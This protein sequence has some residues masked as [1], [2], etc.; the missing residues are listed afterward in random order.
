LFH[1][2]NALEEDKQRDA[3]KSAFCKQLG[4]KNSVF[5]L[6]LIGIT[7]IEV[8][9][10]WDRKYESLEATI[11][12]QRPELFTELPIGKPIPLTRPSIEKLKRSQ[13][14]TNKSLMTSTEWDYESMDP[15]GWYMTEKYDGARLYWNGTEFYTRPGRKI[16]VPEFISSQLPYV[17]LDGELW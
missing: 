13:S 16:K 9:Y 10:W 14:V 2:T 17:K 6:I 11:Y 4:M 5:S 1:G 7:L 12:S 8:P 3:H 15:T